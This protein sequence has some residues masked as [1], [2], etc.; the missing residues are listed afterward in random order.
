MRIKLT[1][2]YDGTDY[3]GFQSQVNGIAIQDVI[4]EV[5]ADL[6]HEP[7][8]IKSASRT[9]TGVH[10][11]GNVAVFD[12]ETRITPSKIALALNARLPEDIRIVD[13]VQVPDDFHPRFQETVKTYEYRILNRK[14]PD[15]M[16]RNLENHI[17]YPLDA[18]KMNRA[19]G[20]LVGEHD[21]ASFCS[22][23]FSSKTTVRT[24]YRAEVI[25]RG[26][27][28]SFFIT[29]NGF[30]YNM[31]R[32]LAG[33][34]IEIGEGKYPPE[35]MEKILAAR[36]RSCAGQTALAKGLVLKEIRYP[37]WEKARQT[38]ELC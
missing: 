35:E 6:F 22:S 24:I 28:I 11:E 1:I 37:E 23:G 25:R 31:V 27:R 38:E 32:I 7:I 33:T 19:A 3:H 13:S 21:F 17:Y 29:G 2:A 9:D 5:L 12:V 30:L 14:F 26:D 18:E 20:Y 36:D 8:R 15:P 16:M 10:A 34:L 4:E